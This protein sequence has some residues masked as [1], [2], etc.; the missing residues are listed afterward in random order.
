MNQTQTRGRT[1]GMVRR[2]LFNASPAGNTPEELEGRA[3]ASAQAFFGDGTELEMAEDYS[4]TERFPDVTVEDMLHDPAKAAR[5]RFRGC[6]RVYELVRD[7]APGGW[8][9]T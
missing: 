8:M 9:P 4:V 6:I 3:L 1:D 5:P 2:R 7:T